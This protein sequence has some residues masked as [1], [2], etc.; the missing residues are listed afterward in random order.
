MGLGD[1]DLGFLADGVC[2]LQGGQV[3]REWAL[4]PGTSQPPLPGETVFWAGV[5]LC[6]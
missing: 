3:G 6:W 1:G 2:S 4:G 5:S